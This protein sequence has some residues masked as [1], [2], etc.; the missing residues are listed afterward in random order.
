MTRL[1]E[2]SQAR[3]RAASEEIG[4]TSSSS[5]PEPGVG[6]RPSRVC[7]VHG[8]GDVGTLA[9]HLRTIGPVQPLPADLTQGIG[10]SLRGGALV[11]CASH[12]PIAHG[13][14]GGD[15]RLSGLGIE[16]AVHPDHARERRGD[17]QAPSFVRLLGELRTP[18][19]LGG[20]APGAD[21]PSEVGDRQRGRRLHQVVL[22]LCKRLRIDLA[23][24]HQHI[25]GRRGDLAGLQS[26]AGGRHLLQRPG[27]S[28]QAGGRRPGLSKASRQPGGDRDVPVSGVGAPALDLCQHPETLAVDDVR[29]PV[30]CGE[31]LLEAV[32]R[33]HPPHPRPGF[34]RARTGAC[35]CDPR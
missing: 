6:R 5:A 20:P 17:V 32:R 28:N 24:G 27:C 4:P 18:G 21:D 30:E 12:L 22:G 1:T 14:K 8:D 9:T 33:L 3:R 34:P 13:P 10:P 26:L 15:D 23:C 19:V 31:F 29:R 2:A 11:C 7:K 35:S 16:V 25:D